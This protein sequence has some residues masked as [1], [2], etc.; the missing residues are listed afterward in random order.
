MSQVRVKHFYTAIE[1][2]FKNWSALQLA[3]QHV[4]ILEPFHTRQEETWR[5]SD[6]GTSLILLEGL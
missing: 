2:I 5:G 3:V 1:A 4:R 6:L